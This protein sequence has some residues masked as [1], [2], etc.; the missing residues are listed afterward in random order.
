MEA[1]MAGFEPGRPSAP[2][3]LYTPA[4]VSSALLPKV[5]AEKF[6]AILECVDTLHRQVPLF[7]ERHAANSERGDAERRLAR[8]LAHPHHSG[9]GDGVGF[10][11][12]EDE[13]A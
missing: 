5:V 2:S 11:L 13:R 9:G 1:S 8:L 6:E 10:G 4:P 3:I 7:E 12:R